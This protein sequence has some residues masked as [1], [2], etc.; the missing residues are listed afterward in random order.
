MRLK[1]YQD[2][3]FG[4]LDTRDF[5]FICNLMIELD[6]ENGINLAKQMD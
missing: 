2:I 3:L 4:E 1:L 6:N 5:E